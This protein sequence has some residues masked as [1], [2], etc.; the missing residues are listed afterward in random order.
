VYQMS[1]DNGMSDEA[2]QMTDMYAK[3]NLNMPFRSPLLEDNGDDLDMSNLVSFGTLDPS[4]LSP[5]HHQMQ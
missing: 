2:L 3:Q 4:S 1:H 5:E